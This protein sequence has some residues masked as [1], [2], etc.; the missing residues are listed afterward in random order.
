MLLIPQKNILKR[1][2]TASHLRIKIWRSVIINLLVG[3]DILEG[4]ID[5]KTYKGKKGYVIYAEKSERDK[6]KHKFTG[7][8]GPIRAPTNIRLTTRVDYAPGVC[9]DYKETGRCGFGDGCIFMHDRGDYK[10]GW[11]LELEWEEKKRKE[12]MRNQSGEKNDTEEESDYEINENDELP[13]FCQICNN[14][15]NNPV[16]TR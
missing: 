7:S 4:K 5:D 1:I 2:E 3:K 10:L 8:L 6:E 9:K 13:K 15:F 16:E 12:N 14:I 11:E